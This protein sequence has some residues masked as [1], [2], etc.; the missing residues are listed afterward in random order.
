MSINS[1]QHAADR[2]VDETLEDLFACGLEGIG[3]SIE[4]ACVQSGI[5][6]GCWVCDGLHLGEGLEVNQ[7][8][9]LGSAIHIVNAAD[10]YRSVILEATERAFVILGCGFSIFFL[11]ELLEVVPSTDHLICIGQNVVHFV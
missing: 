11:E 10:N 7:N 6:V 9:S 3:I 5:V 1:Y 2:V 4:L 8:C